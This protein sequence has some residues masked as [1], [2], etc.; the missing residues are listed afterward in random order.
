MGRRVNLGQRSY[1][2]LSAPSVRSGTQRDTTIIRGFYHANLAVIN[3]GDT[4]TLGP[5]EAAFAAKRL[6]KP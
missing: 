3:M 2:T 4:F 5:D 6:I 1:K